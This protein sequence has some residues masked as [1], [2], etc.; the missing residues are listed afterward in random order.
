MLRPVLAAA[1][2]LGAWGVPRGGG[3]S[4]P[5][6]S[7][8]SRTEPRGF[9][10]R[11]DELATMIAGVDGTCRAAARRAL[12][13]G[14]PDHACAREVARTGRRRLRRSPERFGVVL[15][16]KVDLI[17][18]RLVVEQASGCREWPTP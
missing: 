5:P 8:P 9:T 14:R 6:R 16:R 7:E 4:E 12:L 3:A 10:P 13:G 15:H 11:P 2:V 1:V 18:A 17:G